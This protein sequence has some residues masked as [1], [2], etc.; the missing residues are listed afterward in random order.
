MFKYLLCI[1][2]FIGFIDT[3]EVRQQK[4]D[5]KNCI[6]RI[7]RDN[8]G[9]P[10]I[11]KIISILT[12]LTLKTLPLRKTKQGDESTEERVGEG[13]E[14]ISTI[15]DSINPEYVVRTR[16]FQSER[17]SGRT[18]PVPPQF[19]DQT[20]FAKLAPIIGSYAKQEHSNPDKE[21]ILKTIKKLRAP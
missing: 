3:Q 12:E 5:I 16:P 19:F 1:L 4:S 6:S 17:D 20:P 15:W 9:L 14:V 21:N 2:Q 10:H 11:N 18:S 13:L 8:S 7:R